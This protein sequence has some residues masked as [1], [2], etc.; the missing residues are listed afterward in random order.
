MAVK[1]RIMKVA[2]IPDV[3]RVANQSFFEW[4]R[5]TVYIGPQIIEKYTKFPEW[6][7]VAEEKGEIVGFVIN[8][9]MGDKIHLCWIAVL[10]D[11]HGKGIGG[12][13]LKK[14]E[15]KAI[16]KGIKKIFLD[17]PFARNFYLKYGFKEKEKIFRLVRDITGKKVEKEI[18]IELIEFSNLKDILLFLSKKNSIEF[19]KNYFYSYGR[20]ENLNIIYK[21]GGEIRS[22]AVGVKN[23]FC[24]EYIEIKFLWGKSVKDKIKILKG[25]EYLVSTTGRRGVVLSTSDKFLVKELQKYGYSERK[26]PIFWSQF[27]LEKSLSDKK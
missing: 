20:N 15:A 23:E 11:F 24:P 3:I 8:E 17:T 19:L 22:V 21:K 6:Q 12:K 14:P 5:Y 26:D 25:M 18:G 13:L 1:I 10:P 7:F 27:N 9:V 4:A 2:D 16:K